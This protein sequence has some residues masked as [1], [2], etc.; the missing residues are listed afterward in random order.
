MHRTLRLDL[1]IRRFAAVMPPLAAI[2]CLSACD[3]LPVR[4][5]Y[6]QA[7]IRGDAPARSA[8]CA[9]IF[10]KD[11]GATRDINKAI[12]DGNGAGSLTNTSFGR[13]P[14]PLGK[15]IDPELV[16]RV[17]AA[18][19]DLYRRSDHSV[20]LSVQFPVEYEKAYLH[21]IER[22]LQQH[23]AVEVHRCSQ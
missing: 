21:A 10:W 6:P 7:P 3:L 8:P 19:A 11:L 1:L 4:S 14:A 9:S 2:F 20:D 16:D 13:R 22:W 17:P 23:V 15:R 5:G 18:G 12:L